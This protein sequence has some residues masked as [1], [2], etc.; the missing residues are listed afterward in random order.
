MHPDPSDQL[1]AGVDRHEITLVALTGSAHDQCL[2]VGH[3]LASKRAR[4]CDRVPGREVEQRLRGAGWAGVLRDD[5]A[6]RA[7]EE[8]EGH[9]DGNLEPVPQR[10]A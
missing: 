5:P 2:D 1:I 3:Q 10:V 6:E 4:L 8:E 7:V 9:P